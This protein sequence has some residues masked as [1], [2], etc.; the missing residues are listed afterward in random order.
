MKNSKLI[1]VP[2]DGRHTEPGVPGDRGLREPREPGDAGPAGGVHAPD[3]ASL[4]APGVPM[5]CTRQARPGHLQVTGPARDE[6]LT[7]IQVSQSM[8]ERIRT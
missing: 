6:H 2:P 3:A 4:H 1:R 7:Q 8:A 5:P